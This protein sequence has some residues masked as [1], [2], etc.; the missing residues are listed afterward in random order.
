M[1]YEIEVYKT[2]DGRIPYEEAVLALRDQR[3]KLAIMRRV[4][5]AKLGNLGDHHA[6]GDGL[7]EMRIDYGPGY[8]IYYGRDE[9]TLIILFFAGDKGSQDSDIRKAR[10]YLEDYRSGI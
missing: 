2:A 5:R 6:L 4:Q 1:Q 8:R 7:H 9:A 3:A 10:I